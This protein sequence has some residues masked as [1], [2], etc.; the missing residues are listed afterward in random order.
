MR[1]TDTGRLL[2]RYREATREAR[3]SGQ[4]FDEVFGRREESYAREVADSLERSAEL[5]PLRVRAAE[6]RA[7]A[8]NPYVTR[9]ELLQQG[10]R[11]SA[12]LAGLTIFGF[13]G[14]ASAAP[15]GIP[16]KPP[17]SAPRIA[18]VGAGFAGLTAAYR[19]HSATGWAPTLYEA[20]G[21]V[22]G[23]AKTIRTL[24]GGHYIEAGPSGIG[25][26]QNQPIKRLADDVGLTP[27]DDLWLGYP[28]GGSVLVAGGKTYRFGELAEGFGANQE[29][30]WQQWLQ[31]RKLPT[32]L[33][34]NAAAAHWDSMTIAELF[35]DHLPFGSNTPAGAV[36]LRM[37]E[38]EYAGLAADTSAMMQIA[39]EGTFWQSEK[40]YDERFG[41]P[42]GND[43]LAN[44]VA[45][46]LPDGCLKQRHALVA[47]KRNT[48]DTYTLTFDKDWNRGGGSLVDVVADRVV[49][50]IPPS[51]LR[52]VD[53][54][55]A[56]FSEVKDLA[57]QNQDLGPNSKINIQFEGQPWRDLGFS[58]GIING[59]PSHVGWTWQDSH[60]GLDRTTLIMMN[61]NDYGDA[62]AH[63]LAPSD[64]VDETLA[65]LDSAWGP[66]GVSA[67]A[68]P[69]QA[70]LDYWPNDRW[71]KGSY[72]Y[73]PPGGFIGFAAAEHVREGN[74]HFAGEHT[75]RYTQRGYMN[76]A[77]E[78]GERA[79]RE[80]MSY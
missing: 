10:A 39:D 75:A 42:G 15:G 47:I 13:A 51:T 80:I 16:G 29:F 7:N 54:S 69:G 31:I 12:G 27:L 44:A 48:D 9:R 79:A 4:P 61:N 50:A 28:P 52:D 76:G 35:D 58:G 22:G 74:V 21:R 3:D 64:V 62:P 57:I 24:E 23:R 41:I 20:R 60:L 19:I 73:Y 8:T 26:K 68:I 63:G 30:L 45:D 56:G 66:T 5:E 11:L 18:V 67:H 65:E 59:D 40:I 37:F 14:R 49:L 70:Y 55:G 72:S 36:M 6:L 25:S 43:A 32:Y 17:A 46:A 33:G 71:A 77:V 78:T 53:Y 1:I 2:K 34:Y 38:V